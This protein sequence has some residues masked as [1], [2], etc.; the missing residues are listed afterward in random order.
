MQS[1]NPDSILVA[2]LIPCELWPA[3]FVG[4]WVKEAVGHGARPDYAAPLELA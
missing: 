3:S 1:L 2:T 4:L